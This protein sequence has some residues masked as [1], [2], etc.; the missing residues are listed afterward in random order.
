MGILSVA[1]IP[2]DRWARWQLPLQIILIGVGF[3][4]LVPPFFIGWH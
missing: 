2:W 3:A 1:K 4:L